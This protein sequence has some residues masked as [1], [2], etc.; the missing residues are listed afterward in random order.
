MGA[1]RKRMLAALAGLSCCAW[2]QRSPCYML[3]VVPCTALPAHLA[4]G[5]GTADEMALEE[6]Q[7]LAVEGIIIASVDVL[8]DPVVAAAG[9]GGPAGA[10]P[11]ALAA[12]SAAAARRRIRARIRVTTR[13]MWVDGGRLLEQLHAAA[14]AAVARLP[15]DA[16]LAAVERVVTD[17]MRRACKQFNGRRPDVVVIAHE[18]DPR[19]GAAAQASARR[20]AAEGAPGDAN[21]VAAGRAGT[22]RRRRAVARERDLLFAGKGGEIEDI[23]AATGE[24]ATGVGARGLRVCWW[25][26]GRG[27]GLYGRCRLHRGCLQTLGGAAVPSSSHSSLPVWPPRASSQTPRTRRTLGRRSAAVQPR[28]QVALGAALR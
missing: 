15:G 10:D 21:A 1:P 8:R 12:A 26:W 3:A 14:E 4:Q 19:A 2:Q 23:G 27:E 22:E 13:A 11:A 7:L 24:G 25:W 28:Q 9:G 17:A 16:S 6:R 5:T 20:A 18:A